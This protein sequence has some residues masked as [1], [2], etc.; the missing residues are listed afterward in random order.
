MPAL[1]ASASWFRLDGATSDQYSYVGTPS[2]SLSS[3]V[4]SSSGPK[5]QPQ[6]AAVPARS[7]GQTN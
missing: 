2:L 4:K 3:L 1:F 6:G 7:T 5:V